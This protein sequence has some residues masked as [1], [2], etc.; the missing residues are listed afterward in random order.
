MKTYLQYTFHLGFKLIVVCTLSV[1]LF[2]AG[3]LFVSGAIAAAL[4][5]IGT[6][7]ILV[8]ICMLASFIRYCKYKQF[9]HEI[10]D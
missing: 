8:L 10:E 4:W 5:I 3:G 9:P 2:L 1:V 6:W 7:L